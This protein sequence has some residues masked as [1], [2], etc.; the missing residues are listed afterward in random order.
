MA[1]RKENIK[2]VPFLHDA[3]RLVVLVVQDVGVRGCSLKLSD[4][5]THLVD[6][7]RAARTERCTVGRARESGWLLKH[8]TSIAIVQHVLSQVPPRASDGDG[9]W[10]PSPDVTWLWTQLCVT[11]ELYNSR[12]TDAR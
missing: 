9:V 3:V 5:R 4:A 8:H 11:V 12:A 1:I 7:Q 2:G 6:R 10:T